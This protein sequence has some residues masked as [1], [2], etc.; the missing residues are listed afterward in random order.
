MREKYIRKI[1]YTGKYVDI[2]LKNT[3]IDKLIVMTESR[4][5]VIHEHVV[6]PTRIIVNGISE[7]YFDLN[8]MAICSPY[9]KEGES[10]NDISRS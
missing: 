7:T 8:R 4:D 9:K 6:Y 5:H 3:R 10:G 1:I 2:V